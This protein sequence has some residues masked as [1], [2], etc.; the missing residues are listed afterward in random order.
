ML[1]RGLALNLC[2]VWVEVSVKGSKRKNKIERQTVPHTPLSLLLSLIPAN[3]AGQSW[4][5]APQSKPLTYLTRFDHSSI[6]AS[7]YSSQ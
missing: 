5:K 3:T 6:I 4:T 1:E 2:S 7:K